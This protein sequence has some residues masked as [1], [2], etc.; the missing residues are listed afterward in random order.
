MSVRPQTP[1]PLSFD[2]LVG[3]SVAAPAPPLPP[4]SP[5]SPLSSPLPKIP[6]LPL[7]L[8]L[9]TCRDIIPE[10][11]MSP[12]KRARF[13]APSQRVTDHVTSHRHDSKEFHV[14]HQDAQD[15]EAVLRASASSLKRHRRYHRTT[16]IAAEQEATYAQQAWT[17]SWIIS[18]G[19]QA[20]MQ[21]SAAIEAE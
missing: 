13:A 12:R 19:C 1:L 10:A 11:D 20:E 2:A 7:L 3:S 9:P 17:Q 21:S 5:L 8:P 18:V 14:R 6:S 16:A 15:D 4:P